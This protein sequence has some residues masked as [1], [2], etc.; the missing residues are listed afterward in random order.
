MGG[1]GIFRLTAHGANI[2]ST[3][4]MLTQNGQLPIMA[5]RYIPEIVDGDKRILMVN[6]EP[7]QYCLARIP[8]NGETRGNLAA[9]GL[10][11]ARPLTENDKKIAAKIGPFLKEKG[12]VFVGL[13]VIGFIILLQKLKNLWRQEQTQTA[14]NELKQIAKNEP[15]KFPWWL[16]TTASTA[17]SFMDHP[18]LGNQK[19]NALGLH[20]YRV[21]RAYH[22]AQQRREKLAKYLSAA[23][24]QQ[25]QQN[26]F[27]FKE[28]F[29]P[30]ADFQKLKQELLNQ[31]LPTRETLQGDTVTR[32]M[33]LDYRTLPKLSETQ[34]LLHSSQ[35]QN[36]I[37]YVG[38][39]NI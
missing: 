11:E 22:L 30:D 12:L 19:L 21:K 14:L 39:F 2:G 4:E 35:W 29:L 27:I 25:F 36:L 16:L 24:V 26:G 31:P 23:D 32:R 5:Q 17:S 34:K 18:I 37:N 3:L 10:G 1:M 9:G 8:Q 13:D 20:E 38:S 15:Y 6:G 7:I 33:A 28:N